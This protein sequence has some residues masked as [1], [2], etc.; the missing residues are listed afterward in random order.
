MGRP[1]PAVFTRY[2]A[3]GAA[4]LAFAACLAPVL[5]SAA[6]A[7]G[8]PA[9]PGGSAAKSVVHSNIYLSLTATL[10]PDSIAP[11]GRVV[12][13]VTVRPAAGMRL[14]APGSKYRPVTI[15]L[16]ERSP[17]TLEAPVSYPKGAPYLFKPLNETVPVYDAPF[18]LAARLALDPA[19]ATIAA[20]TRN[21]MT[22]NAALD[23]QA[24]DER[25][26]HAPESVPLRWTV[27]LLPTPRP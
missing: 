26:S 25:A 7:V 6:Q 2:A 1:S 8:G 14:Y 3:L 17:L 20:P 10:T 16:A 19:N 12:L 23:Y 11:G 27:K 22:L 9:P 18:R 13:S 5:T 4:A 15:R 21:E 24:L